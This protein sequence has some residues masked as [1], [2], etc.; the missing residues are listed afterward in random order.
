MNWLNFFEGM[1]AMLII[2]LVAA[3]VFIVG[4]RIGHMDA[5]KDK[6]KG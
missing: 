4:Y 5:K 6:P 1:A 2:E 3:A